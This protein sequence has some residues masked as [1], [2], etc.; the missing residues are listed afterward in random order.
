MRETIRWMAILAAVLCFVLLP[1]CGDGL[2]DDDDTGNGDVW[3]WRVIFD[4]GEADV[5]ADPEEITVASPDTT[6]GEL[7]Q[8]PE[9]DDYYF[10]G[11]WTAP[12]AGGEEFTAA[13]RMI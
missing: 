11:W 9:K 1:G 2:D 6:V 7:P 5:P 8:P 12:E 10:G 13:W 4:S 3:L